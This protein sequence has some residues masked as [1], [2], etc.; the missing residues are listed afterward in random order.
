M[1]FALVASQLILASVL[2]VAGLSKLADRAGSQRG[3]VEFGV[4]ARL[5]RPLAI[6]I[7]VIEVG[8]GIA[9]LFGPT[10]RFGAAA[11]LG[12]LAGFSVLI[13]FNVARGRQPDCHCFGALHSSRAGAGTLIRNGILMALAGFLAWQSFDDDSP[14]GAWSALTDLGGWQILGV[15]AVWA[16]ATML[17]IQP[18][19]PYR[20]LRQ[21]PRF[22]VLRWFRETPPGVALEKGFRKAITLYWT[23]QVRLHPSEGLADGSDAPRFSMPTLEGRS[24]TLDSLLDGRRPVVVYFADPVC[25]LCTELLPEVSAWRADHA[26]EIEIAVATSGS[27]EENL[28]KMHAHGLTDVMI[29]KDR[30]LMDAF[31]VYGTPAALIV[32]PDGS[33]GSEVVHEPADIRMLVQRALSMTGSAARAV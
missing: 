12:V 19:L 8:V 16:L 26:A 25:H 14:S 6:A 21:G 18:G 24:L 7:P 32:G 28:S 17:V 10:V 5:A 29:Q 27:R 11:A 2:L 30:E 31:Q 1:D 4:D 3:I 13:G 33:I 20:L 9:L 23:V 15:V 22:R